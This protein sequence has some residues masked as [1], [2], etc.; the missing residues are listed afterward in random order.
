MCLGE[1]RTINRRWGKKNN[2]RKWEQFLYFISDLTLYSFP[3][4]YIFA[5]SMFMISTFTKTLKLLPPQILWNLFFFPSLDRNVSFFYQGTLL[6]CWLHG[7]EYILLQL[8]CE[9]VCNFVKKYSSYQEY[10]SVFCSIHREHL[11]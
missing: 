1:G 2:N 4:A 11:K 5:V 9:K 3:K 7:P 10:H 6:I 8:S